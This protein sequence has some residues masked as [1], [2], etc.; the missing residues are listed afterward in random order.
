MAEGIEV[1]F[2]GKL[3]YYAVSIYVLFILGLLIVCRKRYKSRTQ[4]HRQSATKQKS[5]REVE[6]KA[7]E[8][9]LIHGKS[10]S[11]QKDDEVVRKRRSKAVDF[12]KGDDGGSRISTPSGKT[13]N[14]KLIE[15]DF[16]E[17][18]ESL[19]F[20]NAVRSDT[21]LVNQET[22]SEKTINML[23]VSKPES[24]KT[25]VTSARDDNRNKIAGVIN[26]EVHIPSREQNSEEMGRKRTESCDDKDSL[27]NAATSDRSKDES[28]DSE[29]E[30][31][32]VINSKL[33]C[34]DVEDVKESC[35]SVSC[36]Y[37]NK[38][39]SDYVCKAIEKNDPLNNFAN[40][41]SS[42]IVNNVLHEI[43]TSHLKT[44]EDQVERKEKATMSPKLDEHI[45]DDFCGRDKISKRVKEQIIEYADNLSSEIIYGYYDDDDI[46][47]MKP[48]SINNSN[49]STNEKAMEMVSLGFCQA[50]AID[51]CR[52]APKT[53]WDLECVS[54]KI[55]RSIMVDAVEEYTRLPADQKQKRL[56]CH[57]KSNLKVEGQRKKIFCSSENIYHD[58]TEDIDLQSFSNGIGKGILNNAI[59]D[60]K[61]QYEPDDEINKNINRTQGQKTSGPEIV[62]NNTDLDYMQKVNE[63]KDGGKTFHTR[64]DSLSNFDADDEDDSDEDSCYSDESDKETRQPVVLRNK[65][66]LK[67]KIHSDRPLSGYAEQLMEFLADD[68]DG[69]DM[70]ESD[71]EFDTVLD[72]LEEKYKDN[73]GICTKIQKRRRLSES[74]RKSESSVD[75]S[76]GMGK[77]I[78][79]LERLSDEDSRGRLTSTM[80]ESSFLSNTDTDD[81]LRGVFSD[82]QLVSPGPGMFISVSKSLFDLN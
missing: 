77:H 2:F 24:I 14:G 74:R 45:S 79:S 61:D 59:K 4:Q 70:F 73:E 20:S 67:L 32:D 30:I 75:T 1:P 48:S 58:D 23:S 56:V 46:S 43:K 21:K 22:L 72:K 6:E 41:S 15:N 81:A 9:G 82:D 35:S 42:S 65:N 7:D 49:P 26:A 57:R 80:S 38:E 17:V 5:H 10:K 11:N 3:T 27:L 71:E 76:R 53:A 29:G 63:E 16:K 66:M 52:D 13:A 50:V 25:F 44:T 8:M 37:I 51:V 36:N 18:K 64:D 60:M 69:L 47:A 19:V 55:S 34:G 40:N 33:E 28:V 31:K 39:V 78:L 62:I 68:D 54:D 12:A